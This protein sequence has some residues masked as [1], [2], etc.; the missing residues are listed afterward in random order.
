MLFLCVLGR[1]NNTYCV[2]ETTLLQIDEPYFVELGIGKCFN[3]ERSFRTFQ[4]ESP[5]GELLNRLCL[6]YRVLRCPNYSYI[7]ISAKE[8]DSNLSPSSLTAIIR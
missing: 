8:A 5:S 3:S 7:V 1:H 2:Y 6:M 4:F